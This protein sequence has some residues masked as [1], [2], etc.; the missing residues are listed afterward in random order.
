MKIKERVD[1]PIRRRR[2]EHLCLTL[3]CSL[4]DLLRDHRNLLSKRLVAQ[5]QFMYFQSHGK[6]FW[7][8]KKEKKP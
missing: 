8:D 1:S 2:I 5:A 6:S 7:Q 3:G 4:E